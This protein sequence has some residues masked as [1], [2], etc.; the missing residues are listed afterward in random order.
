METFQ[1]WSARSK[2]EVSADNVIAFGTKK[3]KHQNFYCGVQSMVLTEDWISI[4]G[5]K[6]LMVE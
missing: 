1:K 5:L 6:V 4:H 2:N 3:N